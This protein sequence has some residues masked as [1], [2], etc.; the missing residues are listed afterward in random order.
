MLSELKRHMDVVKICDSG[1]VETGPPRRENFQVN[2][3]SLFVLLYMLRLLMQGYLKHLV[4][5]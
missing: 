3:R 4:Q 1:S 2:R 5:A